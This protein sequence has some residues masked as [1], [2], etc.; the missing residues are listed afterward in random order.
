MNK[1]QQAEALR[2]AQQVESGELTK[3]LAAR[4]LSEIFGVSLGSAAIVIG[5][6]LDIFDGRVFKRTLS[7]EDLDYAMGAIASQ[8]D[9]AGLEKALSALRMHIEYR[10]SDGINPVKSRAIL[11]K[12]ASL[13]KHVTAE[14]SVVPV[15]LPDIELM[16]QDEVGNARMSSQQERRMR[17]ARANKL[18]LKIPRLVYI[19]ERNPDVVVEVLFRAGG[20]CEGCKVLAPFLRKANGTPY[21]EVHHVV[22]LAEGGEETVEN[23]I[24]LCPNCHRKSHY[25]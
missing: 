8:E 9:A 10:E 7:A 18:P 2:L 20:F 13:L 16:F 21:L 19:Y 5:I 15:Y 3:A 1:E 14:S 22:P 24:A 11:A 4:R 12:Y 25:G 17:L 6:F 23:A